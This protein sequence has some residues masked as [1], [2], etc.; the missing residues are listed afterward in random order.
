VAVPIPVPASRARN[1]DHAQ[2]RF[3]AFGRPLPVPE[4]R[5]RVQPRRGR[6]WVVHR[7]SAQAEGLGA[8]VRTARKGSRGAQTRRRLR[9]GTG[10]SATWIDHMAKRLRA[11][12]RKI[13]REQRELATA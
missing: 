10:Q 8:E 5:V 1:L 6:G 9:Q 13:L 7:Q 3:A 2:G 11:E 4:N 12:A